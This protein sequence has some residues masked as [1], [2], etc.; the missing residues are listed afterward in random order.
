MFRAK[1]GVSIYMDMFTAGTR[2]IP[3]DSILRVCEQEGITVRRKDVTNY[4]NGVRR[5]QSVDLLAIPEYHEPRSIDTHT[6]DDYPKLPDGWLENPVRYFPTD[7]QP[8]KPYPGFKWGSKVVSRRL[9]EQLSPI[10]MVGENLI[11]QPYICLDIDGDHDKDNIDLELL[12]YFAP[13]KKLTES[14]ESRP[15][16][17]HLIFGVDRVVPTMHFPKAHLDILGNA[18]NQARYLKDKT[19][20]GVR[21]PMD[22]K[23]WEQVKGWV[24]SRSKE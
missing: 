23:M 15:E 5:T 9:A 14:W 20:S 17:F 2:L 18:R 24:A 19:P 13:W 1:K 16:S 3:L 6:W 8:S 11:A 21:I 7:T 22:H 10:G 12:S 4:W